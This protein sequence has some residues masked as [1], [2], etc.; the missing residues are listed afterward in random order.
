MTRSSILSLVFVACISAALHAQAAPPLQSAPAPARRG[1]PVQGAEEDVPLV[2]RFDANRD[3]VLDHAERAAAREFILANP[4]LRRPVAGTPVDR[5]GSRGARLT[6][7]DVKV[8][9]ASVSLYDPTALRTVFIDFER[10]DW[11]QELEAFWHTDVEIPATLRVDGRTYPKVGMS[12]RGNNSFTQVPPGLKRQFNITMDA[13]SDQNLLGHTSLNLLNANQDPTFLRTPL[14]L[15]VARDYIPALRAN[16]VRV[17]INGESWGIYPNVEQMNK[18]FLKEWYKT[19]GGVRWKVPGSLNARKGLEYW[20]DNPA[21]YKGAYE[22]KGA[23]DPKAWAAFVQMV[24]VLNTTPPDRLEA[25]LT[26][27]LDIDGALRFI[28]LDNTFTNNDGY[29]TRGSDFAI[30]LD[31]AGKFHIL[32]NDVNEAFGGVGGGFATNGGPFGP[33]PLVGMNDSSKPLRSKLLAVPAL[34]AKYLA[35]TREIATKWLDWKVLEPLVTKY[36]GMIAADVRADTRKIYSFQ[37]FEEGPILLK[38]LADRRRAMILSYA[39]R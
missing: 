21:S 27:I 16:F 4:G 24:R 30:Y 36:Q 32:V 34:R 7:A 17:V 29:W 23:D 31:P 39:P 25:A 9:P 5:T 33:D 2:A 10:D 35:Y 37:E 28:A 12:F 11:E 18:S 14:Y 13:W 6:D 8:Y 38:Q 15:D 22:I 1:P 19:D 26:P 20:G 3:K